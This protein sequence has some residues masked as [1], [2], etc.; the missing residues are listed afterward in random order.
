VCRR[1]SDSCSVG[2]VE[3]VLLMFGFFDVVVVG[4]LLFYFVRTRKDQ[5]HSRILIWGDGII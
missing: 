3:D 5:S 1:N 4:C 2:K